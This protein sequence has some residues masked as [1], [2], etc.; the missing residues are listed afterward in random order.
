MN[1]PMLRHTPEIGVRSAKWASWKRTLYR[2]RNLWLIC[3]PLIAWVILFNYAT[4]YGILMAFVDYIPCK[5]I[6]S[7]Y[8]V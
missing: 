8:W 1:D 7:I 6:L 4:M 3:L 5:S 2:E